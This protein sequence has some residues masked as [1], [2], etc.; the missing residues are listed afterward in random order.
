[1]LRQIVFCAA[2]AFASAS[3]LFAQSAPRWYRGNTHAHTLNSDG[4]SPPDVVARWYRQNGY[5]FTFIT[6]HEYVT[7]VAP[8]NAL[9]GA[10]NRFLLISGQ[11]ITQLVRDSTH[12]AGIRQAHVNALGTT[13]A[14]LPMG[15]NTTTESI[16]TTYARNTAEVRRAGGLAQ[17]N[18]P[19]WHWSVRLADMLALPDSVLLEVA[20]AH[21]GVNNAGGTDDRG[22]LSP[23]TEA[24][25]DSLLTRGKVVFMIADD[26]S[27][28][29]RPENAENP[30]LTRPGR[31]WIWVRAD[32]LTREA[33]L[34]AMRRGDF[35]GSTGVTLQD[36]QA[37]RSALGLTIAPAGDRRF[38]TEFIGSGGRVLATVPG[39]SPRYAIVGNE[40]YVRARVTDSQGRKAWTQPMVV[41]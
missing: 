37:G 12:P 17:V 40:G 23:S 22:N 36:V 15:R 13:R 27:H 3:P 6:D 24:L 34:T 25:W 29:F 32:T 26:D 19:N 41:R 33:I 14:I 8:L 30:A 18:H 1:M 5:H 28:S 20:N 16:A 10:A 21:V 9:L 2:A 4:D 38:T 7:D 39:S 31:A 35:Y 11:E